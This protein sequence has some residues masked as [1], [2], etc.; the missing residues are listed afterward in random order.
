M[1][2]VTVTVF[3]GVHTL[4]AWCLLFTVAST[5]WGK[6]FSV[7][8]RVHKI[9]ERM[10]GWKA[11]LAICSQIYLKKK[12]LRTQFLSQG[13]SCLS[14]K[15]QTERNDAQ[16][17]LLQVHSQAH[18]QKSLIESNYGFKTMNTQ[19]AL[20]FQTSTDGNLYQGSKLVCAV[21]DSV[22]LSY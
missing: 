6:S 18:T 13:H 3:R 9:G 14:P 15:R 21:H 19:G 5:D 11:Q 17:C 8:I 1:L 16:G 10:N 22:F 7:C 20:L 12:G 4:N 2:W